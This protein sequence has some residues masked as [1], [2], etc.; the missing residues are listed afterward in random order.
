MRI[1]WK[2]SLPFDI[3]QMQFL[4]SLIEG[5]WF[6]GRGEMYEKFPA[7]H[8]EDLNT[9]AASCERRR[10]SRHPGPRILRSWVVNNRIIIKKCIQNWSGSHCSCLTTGELCYIWL[11][12]I[13]DLITILWIKWCLQK[14]ISIRAGSTTRQSETVLSC[15]RIWQCG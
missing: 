10:F 11:I 9:Q 8:K 3:F 6:W 12:P 1:S 14:C 15:S 2:C 13:N 7:Q 5:G 4:F